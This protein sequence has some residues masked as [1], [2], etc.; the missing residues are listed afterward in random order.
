MDAHPA[1]A[2]TISK[3]TWRLVPFLLLMYILAFL[4]RANVGFAKES[5]Q[6]DTGLSEAAYAFGAGVFFAGYA[7]LEVPSNLIMHRVGARIWMARIMVTWG[8]VSAAMMFA[9]TATMFYVLRLLLGI[10]EAGFFPGVILYLT[11]WFPSY[12]RARVMGLFYFG[13]PLAFILGG[14]ISGVLLE[15]DGVLGLQGWQ[16]MFLVEGLLASAT[17]IWAYFYIDDRPADASWLNDE[18]K[19]LLSAAVEEDQD[20]RGH[21]PHGVLAALRNPGVLYLSAIYFL[22]QVAVYGVVFYLPTQVAQ[23]LGRKVGFEVGL[24]TAIPWICALI[25]AYLIPRYSDLKNDRRWTAA[26]TLAVA[27][28]GIAASAAASD[29]PVLA[30]IALCFAASGF[31]AVQPLFWTFPTGYLS[32]AAAAGGIALVNSFGAAGG[33]TGP[34]VRTWA[35]RSFGWPLAGLYVLALAAFIGA[36]LI[37]M[38]SAMLPGLST[39]NRRRS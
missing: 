23:L 31:I 3:A 12:A 1:L 18:E 10:A 2:K 39:D 19:R 11:Y 5:F 37:A 36:I 9:H 8:L 7:L 22:I 17:G 27:G 24:V 35:E 16:W 6:I 34:I 21:G 13:A 29:S 32:G 20:K 15:M 30:L 28:A 14:P 25:A 4:D 26:V 38:L 33:F